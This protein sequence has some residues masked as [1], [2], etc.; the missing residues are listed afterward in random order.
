MTT[1]MSRPS[2][3]ALMMAS[4]CGRNDEMPHALL[5]LAAS[6]DDHGQRDVA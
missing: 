3:E 2:S 1:T 6:S 5:S 4:C